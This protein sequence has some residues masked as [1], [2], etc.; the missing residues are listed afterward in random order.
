MWTALV[1]NCLK[2]RF[3]HVN[4][5]LKFLAAGCRCVRERERETTKERKKGF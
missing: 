1:L 5:C 4:I 3:E 2:D